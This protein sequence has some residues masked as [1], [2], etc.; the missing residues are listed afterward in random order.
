M[1]LND[2]QKNKKL[3]VISINEI[4]QKLKLRLYEIGFYPSAE[5]KVLNISFLKHTILVQVLDSCF[6]IK[7]SIAKNIEVEY[8]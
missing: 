1:K 7:S 6:A 4:D 2:C 8:D 3:N 5:I